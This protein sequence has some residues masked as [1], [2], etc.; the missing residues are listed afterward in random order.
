MVIGLVASTK[1]PT[2]VQLGQELE[3]GWDIMEDT[4]EHGGSGDVSQD[5]V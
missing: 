2:S 3:L 4:E 5:R 1:C